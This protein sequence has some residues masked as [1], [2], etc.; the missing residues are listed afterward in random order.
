MHRKGQYM[1]ARN[2]PG[3]FRR[4]EDAQETVNHTRSVSGRTRAA[5][6]HDREPRFTVNNACRGSNTD[7]IFEN[8]MVSAAKGS[9]AKELLAA[10]Q[11]DVCASWEVQVRINGSLFRTHNYHPWQ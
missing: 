1:P 3:Y 9:S 5:A 10:E 4:G 7:S 8:D 6:S 2:G 11:P